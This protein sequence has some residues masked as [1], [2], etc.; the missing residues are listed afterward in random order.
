MICQQDS[1][2]DFTDGPITTLPRYRNALVQDNYI[3]RHSSGD[4]ANYSKDS[5]YKSLNDAKKPPT[6]EFIISPFADLRSSDN[7]RSDFKLTVEDSS[8]SLNAEQPSPC[9]SRPCYLACNSY[10]FAQQ[11]NFLQLQEQISKVL[12]AQPDELIVSYF[13]DSQMWKCKYFRGSTIREI[14][15]SCYW[16]EVEQD[17]LLEV[18]RV[19]G[20]GF[21]CSLD[22]LQVLQNSLGVVAAS[23]SSGRSRAFSRP[24]TPLPLP[25]RNEAQRSQGFEAGLSSILHM[26]N[27]SFYETRLEAAKMLCDLFSATNS[28]HSRPFLQSRAVLEPVARSLCQL[29]AERVEQFEEVSDVALMALSSL[30]KL[31]E[32]QKEGSEGRA[33][34]LEL[35]LAA[36]GECEWLMTVLLDQLR[37]CSE[38]EYFALGHGRRLAGEVLC[39]LAES[40]HAEVLRLLREVVQQSLGVLEAGQWAQMTASIHRDALLREYVNRIGQAVL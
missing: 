1:F 31:L 4:D 19:Y 6:I 14:H 29:V 12:S 10:F 11:K 22:L 38:E 5:I 30:F 32:V 7:F 9:E 40:R 2:Y 28:L 25:V 24:L 17:H 21:G 18:R 23:S 27:D 35:L 39:L 13:K 8:A 34:L 36:Q 3:A 26:A 15:I 37:D 33:A 16:D 20:D